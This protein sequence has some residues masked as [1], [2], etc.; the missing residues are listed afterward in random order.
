MPAPLLLDLSH[1]SHSRAR[2]GIQRVTRSLSAALG[3]RAIAVTHDPLRQTWRGLD[4]WEQANLAASEAAGKRSAKW[5]L[6][7]RLH[8]HTQRILRRRSAALPE[9]SGVICPEVFSPAVGRALPGLFGAARGPR[10]AVFHDAIALKLP[11]LTPPATVARFPAYLVE[12][13]RFDGIAAVSE[14]SG[15]SL[16]EYW[17]W[18]GVPKHPPVRTISLG[19]MPRPSLPNGE[20]SPGIT[21]PHVLSVGSIEGRKNHIALLNAC[22]QLWERGERFRLHLIGLANPKTGGAALTKLRALQAA[23]RPLRYDGAVSDGHVDRAYADCTFTVYPSI[24]EGFGLPVIESLAH[25]KP[26]ICSARGAL[27][28]S[29]QGGGCIGLETMEAPSIAAAMTRLIHDPQESATLSAQ[30]R[31][32]R[33][34]TWNEYADEL[35]AWIDELR[36]S[37]RTSP[38]H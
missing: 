6:R 36:K 15:S 5:P 2:T 8:A 13:L 35:G 37:S 11:E 7:V 10:V 23:A 22:E 38:A 34:K 31:A 29:A 33:F 4:R 3:D 1:T 18:L 30:A 19:I 27:G 12:L 21:E 25:G 24:M 28:E 32:R 14:D 26:C 9:N 17:S 16:L 20:M